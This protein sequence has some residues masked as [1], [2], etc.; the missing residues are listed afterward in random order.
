MNN[1]YF[2]TIGL[3]IHIVLNTNTKMFSP[4]KSTHEDTVNNHLNEIDLAL[5]GTMPSVNENAVRK[6]IVLA[7]ALHMQIHTDPISFDRKNYFY[8]DLPKNFQITQ[9]FNPIGTNGYVILDDENQTKI[10]IERI[11]LEEDTAKQLKVENSNDLKLNY[12][13]AG[14]P[15]I[16]IVS[17]PVL[18]SSNEVELYLKALREI[19]VFMDVSDAKMEEGSMRVDVNL[20]LSKDEDTFGTKVE[21]KNINSI[22]NAKL[23]AEYEIKRQS[24]ILD[25]NEVV[26]QETRRFDD[27]TLTTVFMRKKADA[28]DYRYMTEPNI[29]AIYVP[30]EFVSETLKN[31]A[32]HPYELKQVLKQNNINQKDINLLLSNKKIYDLFQQA[33][34]LTLDYK[35]A[36]RWILNELMGAL[37]KQEKTIESLNLNETNDLLSLIKDYKE[38]KF[39]SKQAK[40]LFNEVFLNHIN[41]SEALKT[42]LQNSKSYSDEDILKMINDILSNNPSTKQELTTRYEKAEKFII[43]SLMKQTKGQVNPIKVKELLNKFK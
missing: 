36:C 9:Q 32:L 5:P 21:V 11:Q 38:N 2:V 35:D 6:G 27:T 34:S 12:N 41:Y 10:S 22:T 20:S 31:I 16:E 18:H 14:M 40:D 28:I 8:W 7:N 1:K 26:Q 17:K 30:K 29:L 24:E 13:R 19:C 43:G 3:E 39:N 37:N 23:A 42:L 33:Y 15:L 4:A 25:K